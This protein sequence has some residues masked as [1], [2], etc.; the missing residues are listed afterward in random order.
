MI[1]MKKY[2]FTVALGLPVLFFI[3]GSPAATLTVGKTAGFDY[4]VIQDAVDAAADGDTITIGPGWYEEYQW[5]PPG[6]VLYVDTGLKSLTIIGSGPEETII[7][8]EDPPFAS[9]VRTFGMEAQGDEFSIR[10][11]SFRNMTRLCFNFAYGNVTVDNCGFLDSG[12]G[13]YLSSL[14]TCV[15]RDCHFENLGWGVVPYHAYT[16]KLGGGVT[17]AS[18]ENCQ[19]IEADNA[20]G[21]W[22]DSYDVTVKDCNFDGCFGG[23]SFTDGAAGRVQRCDF[24]SVKHFSLAVSNS[25]N[26]VMEDCTSLSTT[27]PDLISVGVLVFYGPSTL[28][29]YRNIFEMQGPG[30]CL[31]INVN[32]ATILAEDNHFLRQ[33]EDAWFVKRYESFSSSGEPRHYD[34][35]G[36]WWGTT[37]LD[38]IST[39]IED[40]NDDPE[41]L[42]IVDFEPIL[43]HPVATQ[44]KNLGDLKSLFRGRR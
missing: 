42:Y 13:L 9:H 28:S 11:I 4:E 10:D 37:D 14:D 23:V 32:D 35:S 29:L 1:S 33:G 43:D 3:T 5:V 22:W 20:I 38:T 2:F 24:Q 7:G 41:Q 44:K 16:I 36:N 12:E 8:H 18:I 39:W 30:A 40:Y 26:V 17:S 15:V 21:T 19:F 31:A 34:L 25:G 27:I 6:E